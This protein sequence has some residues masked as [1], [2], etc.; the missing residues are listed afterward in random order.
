MIKDIMKSKK[1][2]TGLLIMILL[3]IT[4]IFAPILSPCDPYQP[5]IEHRLQGP[6]G[7]FPFGNDYLGRCVFSRIIYGSRLSLK[8]AFIIVFL[9][10]LIGLSMGAVSGYIGGM[11]D[12]LIMRLVDVFMALPSLVLALVLVALTGPGLYGITAA[13]CLTGWTEYAR[14]ARGDVLALKEKEFIKSAKAFGFSTPYILIRHIIPNIMAPILV[15][16]TLSAGFT[17]LLVAAFSFIGIGAQPPEADWGSM[18]SEGR[19]FMRMAPHLTVFPGMAI[20][21][22]TLSFYL[23]GDALRDIMDPRYKTRDIT[24]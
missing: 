6:S 10:V 15:L 5:N 11:V 3:V 13:M 22:T 19:S 17:I 23:F 16:A 14:V 21:V 1:A 18:L 20:M 7:E 12:G 8:V 2:A 9:Q 24:P 4:A